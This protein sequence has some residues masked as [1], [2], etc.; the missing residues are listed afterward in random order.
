[1]GAGADFDFNFDLVLEA[2]FGLDIDVAFGFE[3]VLDTELGFRGGLY[4]ETT[5]REGTLVV[6]L[7]HVERR[8]ARMRSTKLLSKTPSTRME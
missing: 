8:A 1:M 4:P 3:M 5:L 7:D 2:G 6:L